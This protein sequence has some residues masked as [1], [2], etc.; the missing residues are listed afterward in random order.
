MTIGETRVSDRIRHV[1]LGTERLHLREFDVQAAPFIVL[2]PWFVE[3][4]AGKMGSPG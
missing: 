2:E 4:H 3:R 1:I